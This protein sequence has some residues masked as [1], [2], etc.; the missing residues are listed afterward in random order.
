VALSRKPSGLP[1]TTYAAFKRVSAKEAAEVALKKRRERE[2]DV[3]LARAREAQRDREHIRTSPHARVVARVVKVDRE[4][5][6]CRDA[7]GSDRY[8]M[9][10]RLRAD[11]T[12][13]LW[14]NN[15]LLAADEARKVRS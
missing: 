13:D 14:R 7:N 4:R 8:L 2:Y 6:T 12:F 15:A 9:A 5:F 11:R 1:Y 3:R 10:L